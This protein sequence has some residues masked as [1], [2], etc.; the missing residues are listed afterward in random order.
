MPLSE[1]GGEVGTSVSYGRGFCN[2]FNAACCFL[3]IALFILFCLHTIFQGQF[4]LENLIDKD[5]D[6]EFPVELQVN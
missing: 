1:K 6:Y 4:L 5:R 3:M 2:F